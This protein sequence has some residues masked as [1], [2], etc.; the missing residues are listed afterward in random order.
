MLNDPSLHPSSTD[1]PEVPS[2]QAIVQPPDS[3]SG[4]PQRNIVLLIGV[5]VLACVVLIGLMVSSQ[6][7]RKTGGNNDGTGNEEISP[8]LP[9]ENQVVSPTSAVVT[10]N[11]RLNIDLYTASK[12]E[13][14]NLFFSPYSILS[15][16]AMTYEGARGTTAEEMRTVLHLPTDMAA[17]RSE[18][19]IINSQLNVANKPYAVSVANA[20]WAQEN[21]AF[22]REY[23]SLVEQIYGGAAVNLDFVTKLEVSRLTINGWV[24]AQTND[25]IK[26][27]IP[28]GMLD[29][30][31][32][33]V[34]TNAIYFKGA[35][36]KAFNAEDTTEQRFQLSPA[37][38]KLVQMM[39]RTDEEAVFNYGEDAAA[40]LLELP[41]SGDDLSMVVIL[42]KGELASV[43]SMLTSDQLD[44]WRRSL[45]EQRVKVFLPRFKFETKY[46]M[47]EVLS[48]LGMPTA[49]SDAADFTG[50]EDEV[51]EDVKIGE[52]IH[53]AFVEVNE[54]GTEAAAAT[55][56]VMLKST[57][58]GGPEEKIPT[59]R[60]DH[61]FIFIIQQKAS[62]N[63]LFMGRVVDPS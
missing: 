15:A 45:T 59:F 54:E 52:V 28:P 46:M 58:I 36:T 24:E 43:E 37:E 1:V 11:N 27:L 8:N 26:D 48:A 33:L 30:S 19:G 6:L 61:P 31:T 53:Q 55:A 9:S 57:S 13:E 35:W 12:S 2:P 40:Q 3:Q 51:D 5:G 49:F 34:L 25:K 56:V 60:A 17:A 29:E 39:Q 21:F 50:M 22:K 38:H 7:P 16:L 32:R 10:A 20:L 23:L 18:F 44:R 42:P 4:N 62:G 14:G 41:Y 63:I 47:K